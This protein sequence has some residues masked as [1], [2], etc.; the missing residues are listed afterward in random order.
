MTYLIYNPLSASN[1]GEK[2][3]NKALKDLKDFDNIITLDGTKLVPNEFVKSLKPE[4]SIILIG[5]D[6][7]LNIFANQY[8]NFKV[9][10]DIYLYRGGSGNDFLNDIEIKKEK[11]VKINQYL[12]NLPIL[13][14]NGEKRY[15]INNVGFGLDGEVCVLADE[16]K[17]RGKK[18]VNYTSTALS[19]LLKK[20]NRCN[21]KV[22]VDGVEKVYKDVWIASAMNGRYCG[23]GM[24][25]A[26][27]QDRNS[28]YITCVVV[29][30]QSR[31]HTLLQFPSIFKGKHVKKTYMVDF[32]KCKN[33][34]IEFNEPKGLQVDGEVY[35]G[36][37]KYKAHI[38]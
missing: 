12:K 6:G 32:I 22:I 28:G 30:G 11:Y 35:K 19:L 17:A 36:V 8:M 31:L 7:T 15:F 34:E 1:K 25:L 38:E 37:T 29:Y 18:K 23:G 14:I 5:G 9:E 3:K 16:A 2:I 26:P 33:I 4:D 10:N 20:Y 13:E 21:A 24:M 27:N